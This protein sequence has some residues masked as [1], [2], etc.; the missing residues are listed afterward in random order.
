MSIRPSNDQGHSISNLEAWSWSNISPNSAW[1]LGRKTQNPVSWENQTVILIE[2]AHASSRLM[3]ISAQ[4]SLHLTAH[5]LRPEI[6]RWSTDLPDLRGKMLISMME[7]DSP[8]FQD[9][10]ADD[11][12]ALQTVMLHSKRV[13]WVAMGE[14]PAMQAAVGYLRVLQN[15]NVDLDLR[16]LLLNNE[17]DTGRSPD[18]IAQTVAAMAS[19]P[20][21]DREY[22]ELEGCIQI[23]RWVDE[24]H[25]SSIMA[26]D[27]SSS[28]S[29]LIRLGDARVPLR[30]EGSI[31]STVKESSGNFLADDEVNVQV[32]AMDIQ[33]VMSPFFHIIED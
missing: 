33:Y 31:Y 18:H 14:D 27:G 2:P 6:V 25:L 11:F 29:D 9:L 23:N 22:M 30:L 16:Y 3:K 15:E 1:N 24:D 17:A 28:L 8:F 20:T 19:S 21:T 12:A 32:M 10:C 26:A 5:G 13:L 4:L 7:L